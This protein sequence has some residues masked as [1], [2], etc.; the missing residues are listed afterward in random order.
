MNVMIQKETIVQV[1]DNSGAKT[2]RCIGFWRSRIGG[3]GDT[4]VV[5]VQRVSSRESSVVKSKSGERVVKGE[6]CLAYVVQTRQL[7]RRK[8]GIRVGFSKSAVVLVNEKGVPRGTR[9][10]A[11]EAVAMECKN[12]KILSLASRSA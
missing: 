5:S 7:T 4:I 8:N 3:L 9:I 1:I 10:L 11:N 12:L 6:V 2:A